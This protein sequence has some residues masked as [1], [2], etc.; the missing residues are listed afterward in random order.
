MPNM[1]VWDWVILVVGAYL[2]ITALVRLMRRRRDEVLAQL[3]AEAKAERERQRL[4][5]LAAKREARKKRR[6]A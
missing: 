6:A 1:D 2:A 5:E 3:D 4:A